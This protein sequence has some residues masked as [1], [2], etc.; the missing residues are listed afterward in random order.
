MGLIKRK[1][2]YYVEFYV[3]DDG[4]KLKLARRQDSH[5]G[6]RLQRWCT[7]SYNKSMAKKQEDV[8][9]VELMTEKMESKKNPD[10]TVR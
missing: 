7:E 3:W 2:K 6:A 1:G 10:V 9:K 8:I 4:K 5:H